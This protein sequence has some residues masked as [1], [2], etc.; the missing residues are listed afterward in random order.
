MT[1]KVWINIREKEL[2]IFYL[3][4]LLY[5]TRWCMTEKTIKLFKM[6]IIQEG[7][8]AIHSSGQKRAKN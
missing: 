1:I 5:S 3:K 6:K 7:D 2:S 8:P 4:T